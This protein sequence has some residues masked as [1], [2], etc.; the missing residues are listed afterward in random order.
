MSRAK[1]KAKETRESGKRKG[2]S[3][4]K[5]RRESGNNP[6]IA[7]KG[8]GALASVVGCQLSETQIGF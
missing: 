7:I 8:Q 2:V 6:E 4:E 3:Q 1:R 5:D